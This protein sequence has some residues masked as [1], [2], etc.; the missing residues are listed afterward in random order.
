MAESR[1]FWL[2][3]LSGGWNLFE[4]YVFVWLLLG[5]WILFF[6]IRHWVRS[7]MP[8]LPVL[9]LYLFSAV[10]VGRVGYNLYVMRTTVL[11][12]QLF[13]WMHE[14]QDVQRGRFYYGRVRNA[15]PESCESVPEPC[16]IVELE[17]GRLVL[18][19]LRPG[20]NEPKTDIVI[21][22]S[23]VGEKTREHYYYQV[24]YYIDGDT[25]Y[26]WSELTR[27]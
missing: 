18:A 21:V 6:L 5:Y 10:V 20:L 1:E 22:D 23:M 27:Q 26:R 16:V 15:S 9:L 24:D 2:G 17:D 3:R 25:E 7:E 8:P 13:H 4:A 19:T 12:D 11:N 14:M